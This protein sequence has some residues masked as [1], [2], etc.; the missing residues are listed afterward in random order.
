MI[1]IITVIMVIFLPTISYPLKPTY[2]VT[3][4]PMYA[5]YLELD[6]QK[7][8]TSML[9]EL[10]VKLLRIPTYWSKVEAVE[11]KYDFS[12]IDFIV[13][14]AEK[15]GAKIVLVVGIKQP[16]WPEYHLPEWAKGINTEQKQEKALKLASALVRRYQSSPTI[17]AW[18]VENEPF[19][20]WF[21]EDI[22]K[23][24]INQEFLREE[25]SLVKKLDP[26]RK[27][28]VTDTG[29]WS[30][31]KNAMQS[32]D[33]LGVSIYRKAHNPKFGYITYPFFPAMYTIKSNLARKLFAPHPPAGGQKTIISELQAEPWLQKG[34]ME[35]LVSEQARLF[36]V[37]ELEGNV[38][39]AKKTGFNEIYLWG[40]EWWYYMASQGHP[41]YLEYAK[42]IF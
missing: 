21:G 32:G 39:F 41:E 40:V 3:F 12:E 34:V 11:S 13:S 42:N 20:T 9:D 29:E 22:D 31:W 7:T 6:W 35:S 28:I 17:T 38:N 37:K 18:Q 26:S 24:P 33:I 25:I 10:H 36:S 27:V 30:L 15:R 5:R 1:T 14:E 23:T 8:Y 2:G 19:V 4:S 16:R